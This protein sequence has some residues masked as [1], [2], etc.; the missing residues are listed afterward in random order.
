MSIRKFLSNQLSKAA[1]ALEEDRSKE[2]IETLILVGRTKLAT[3][4]M[5]KSSTLFR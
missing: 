2:K 5:P 4:I 1:K 3:K